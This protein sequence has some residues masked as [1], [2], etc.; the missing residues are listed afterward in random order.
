MTAGATKDGLVPINCD[1]GCGCKE[2]WHQ[3]ALVIKPNNGDLQ[4]YHDYWDY[5][6]YRKD[7]DGRWSHKM[8]WTPATNLDNSGN[9]IKDPRTADRGS[10][11]I[12]CG[13]FCVNKTKVTI[14]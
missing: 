7:R 9:I 2:C 5:H 1:E 13:C 6:W 11:T 3:V 4:D 14:S 12:F 10:Y 8:A